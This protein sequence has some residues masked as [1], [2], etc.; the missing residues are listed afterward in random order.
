MISGEYFRLLFKNETYKDPNVTNETYEDPHSDASTSWEELFQGVIMIIAIMIFKIH[1][2][3]SFVQRL[4]LG[5][6]YWA[7]TC[8]WRAV[9]PEVPREAKGRKGH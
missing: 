5:V 4:V 7:C 6:L 1:E 8:A 9:R 3:L 2:L